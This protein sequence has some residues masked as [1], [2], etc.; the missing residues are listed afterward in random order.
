VWDFAYHRALHE[1]VKHKADRPAGS[2]RRALLERKIRGCTKVVRRP[3]MQLLR[4][5]EKPPLVSPQR[6]FRFAEGYGRVTV[7]VLNSRC[8]FGALVKA[9]PVI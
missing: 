6:R 4:Y 8:C 1:K 5:P 3:M 2:R 9:R 7:T